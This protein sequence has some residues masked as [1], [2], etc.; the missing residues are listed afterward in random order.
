M[1]RKKEIAFVSIV[2]KKKR[3]PSLNPLIL[4][5]LI[6]RSKRKEI[7]IG[8]QTL[9]F[10]VV[11]ES[12]SGTVLYAKVVFHSSSALLSS[13]SSSPSVVL[14][15]PFMGFSFMEEEEAASEESSGPPSCFG[16]IGL[17][18]ITPGGKKPS[19]SSALSWNHGEEGMQ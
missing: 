6:N 8:I 17:L 14:S 16:A 4:P 3:E 9:R 12:L 2:N 5:V 1:H 15:R 19:S 7:V 10:E 18:S 11:V 13:S